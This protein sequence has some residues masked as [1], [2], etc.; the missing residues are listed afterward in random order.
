[1]HVLK[2]R[3]SRVHKFKIADKNLVPVLC[4][5]E[6]NF[7]MRDEFL[8]DP[9]RIPKLIEKNNAHEVSNTFEYNSEKPNCE[10]AEGQKLKSISSK[11]L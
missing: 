7:I 9:A 2:T 8:H 5:L 11:T 1:M 4:G 3:Q 6:P 10:E